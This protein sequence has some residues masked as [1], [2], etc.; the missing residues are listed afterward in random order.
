MDL[1]VVA[2]AYSRHLVPGMK[3]TLACFTLKLPKETPWKIMMAHWNLSVN[4]I[5]LCHGTYIVD[6][7]GLAIQRDAFWPGRPRLQWRHLKI[8]R[9][10]CTQTP[11]STRFNA[12]FPISK[13]TFR[14]RLLT[15]GQQWFSARHDATKNIISGYIKSIPIL[16]YSIKLFLLQWPALALVGHLR[17]GKP[18]CKT[19]QNL[20]MSKSERLQEID[21]FA[22][23]G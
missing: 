6:T 7:T 8:Q 16:T 17:I 14:F 23:S 1:H 18:H 22:G 5:Q 9:Q 21:K 10:L 13:N 15:S 20:L 12:K 19:Y 2:A 4:Q 3:G 11:L